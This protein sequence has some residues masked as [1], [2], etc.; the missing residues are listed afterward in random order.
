MLPLR[1]LGDTGLR[2]SPMTLGTVKIGRD[3]QVKYP[4]PFT[5]PDDKA[6]KNLFELAGSLGVNC[7]DTAPAYGISEQRI[8]EVLGKATKNWLICTKTGEEFINGNS[9][10]DFSPEHTRMSVERSLKRLHRDTLDIVLV[11]SDGNDLNIIHRW[12]TLEVLRELKQQ[13]LI[14]AIGMSTKTVEGGIEALKQSDIVM[15]TYNLETQVEEPVLSFAQ[16]HQK[17]TFIK[18]ALASGHVCEGETKDPIRASMELVFAHPGVTSITIGTINP[19]HLK[20][21]ISLA[22]DVLSGIKN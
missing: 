16:Q 3:Q 4:R 14:R 11:H 9:V 6:V 15:A 21:N 17:A 13:G 10:F 18:K 1:P 8:G 2:I 5:I 19:E 12:G 20:Q 22:A 7:L